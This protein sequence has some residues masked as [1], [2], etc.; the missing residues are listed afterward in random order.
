MVYKNLHKKDFDKPIYEVLLNQKYFSGIGNYL[1][2]TILYYLD[3]NPFQPS[4]DIIK[5]HPRLLDL[6]RD[7]P[8]KS[9]EFH[10]GQLQDWKNPFDVDSSNFKEWVYYQ[11][12]NS[13]KDSSNRNFWYDPKWQNFC[14][15]KS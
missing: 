8:L 4:R 7:I 6:C 14:I 9:Y 10:G 15:K 5:N 2:S 12:G 13:V 3:I 1:R 11:K